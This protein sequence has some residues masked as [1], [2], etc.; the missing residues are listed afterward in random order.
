MARTNTPSPRWVQKGC[1]ETA[2]ALPRDSSSPEV[3]PSLAMVPPRDVGHHPRSSSWRLPGDCT[4]QR[5][6]NIQ[7]L[8]WRASVSPKSTDQDPT[9]LRFPKT[10]VP[11][12]QCPLLSVQVPLLPPHCFCPFCHPSYVKNSPQA[13][14]P[15][16][17]SLAC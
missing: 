9:A 7:V 16:W 6:L 5:P 8:G 2:L 1:P 10:R 17:L 12:D 11:P 15:P 14:P 3:D 13:A 4:E